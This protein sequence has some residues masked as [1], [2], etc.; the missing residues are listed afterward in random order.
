[1]SDQTAVISAQC[2]T[3][4]LNG[5]NDWEEWL[6]II[7]SKTWEHDIWEFVNSAMLKADVLNLEV[8]EILKTTDVNS[9]VTSIAK[10][11]N[12]EKNIYWVLLA[13]YNHK[14]I[15]YDQKMLVLWNLCTFIQRTIF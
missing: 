10:L 5:P 7:K 14:I 9:D 1:M 12:I 6:E 15:T 4:I 8:S 3:V 13:Q 2:V 11:E